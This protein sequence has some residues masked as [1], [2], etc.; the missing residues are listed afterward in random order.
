MTQC[1]ACGGRLEREMADWHFKCHSCGYEFATLKPAINSEDIHENI[2]E[3]QRA[4]ALQALR[5][6]NFSDILS[7]LKELS[8][9]TAPPRRL[10][11]VGA[12]HGWF[13]ELARRNFD[14]LGVEPDK[15]VAEKTRA[16]GLPVRIGFF[17]EVID[18]TERF[19]AIAFND[20]IEHIPDVND[21]LRACK[22]HLE[23]GG[24]LVLNLPSSSGI[25]YRL[26]KCLARL[27]A[28]QFFERMWQMGMPSPHVH[29]FNGKSLTA[30]LRTQGFSLVY[31]SRLDSIT[32]QG[33]LERI[34]YS[35]KFSPLLAYPIYWIILLSLPLFR[36][37]PADIMLM[38]FKPESPTD[39]A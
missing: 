35:K 26:A 24:I 33:L 29:Y 12:A 17:P 23:M 6:R 20:V 30:L 9:S 11:D 36:I 27:G 10:L 32:S 25:F 34:R 2:D 4:S 1:I 39:P 8:P 15:A 13:L 7:V 28:P 5:Y 31:A 14:V 38:I 22:N 37:L 3:S 16:K 18:P 19:H 21:A